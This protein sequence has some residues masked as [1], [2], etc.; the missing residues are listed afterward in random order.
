[1]IPFLPPTNPDAPAL[2][3]SHAN[4]YTPGCYRQLTEALSPA[5]AVWGAA[6]R[7][8]WPGSRPESVEDW[9]PFADD[10]IQFFDAHGLRDV[11]GV[12]HSL[13][14]VVTMFAAVRRPELFRA[15][16]LIEPVFFLPA[17]LD[18]ARRQRGHVRP[19]EIPVVR[20][21]LHRRARWP[22][23]QAAFDHLRPKRVFARLP[24][25]ALWDY[26]NAGMAEADDGQVILRFPPTWEARIYSLP[27]EDVWEVLPAVSQPTL[28]IR[29]AASDT[30]VAEAWRLWQA[31][32]PQATFLEIPASDH[33]VPFSHPRQVA[34]AI[35]AFAGTPNP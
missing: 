16:V 28:G 32:Q 25:A 19:E 2:H 3:L 18:A 33:L 30:L 11:V 31:A 17:F 7:P 6:H 15:L 21:A 14:G 23:R 1:M 24:D 20:T 29:G 4:A 35:L 27:P 9:W 34:E 13:G 22:S 26:V 10:L 12:G 8:L 5:F